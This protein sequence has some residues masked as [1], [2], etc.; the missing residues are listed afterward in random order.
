[1][2]LLQILC[3]ADNPQAGKAAP[4]GSGYARVRKVVEELVK[5]VLNEKKKGAD[6]KVCWK[7]YR[8]AG[9]KD[10]KDICIKVNK[11]K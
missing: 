5:Q 7:G 10:G 8:Y 4:Y 2:K 6:G 11:S 3:E 1:M 9:T